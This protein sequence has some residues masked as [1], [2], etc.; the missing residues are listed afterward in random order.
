LKPIIVVGGG[1]CGLLTATQLVRANIP[2]ILIERKKYPFHRVCGEYISNE[3][4]P[5]LKRL[6]LFPEQ[7]DLPEISRFQ[8]SSI[9]GVSKTLPLQLGGFGISRF[10]FDNFLYEQA[11][12]S[13]VD[14]LLEEDVESI[15]FVDNGF[16]I[17]TNKRDLDADFVIGCFGKR[18]KVDV[19]LNR[20]F[21]SKRS[22]YVGIKHHVIV[23]HPRDLIGLHNFPGGY[24]GISR[25][26]NDI[27]NLC[28]L[29]HRD[30]LRQYKNIREMES[31]ILCRNPLLRQIFERAE[32]I[33][34]R[35]ET[36]NEISFETKSPVEQHVLMGGDAAGMI[37]PLCGNG[38]SI[39]MHTSK[40]ISDILRDELQNKQWSRERIEEKY[41]R[42]WN[43]MFARRLWFGRQVQRLFG[44]ETASNLAV[45]FILG[46][47]P[48]ANM[49]IRNTHGE[50]FT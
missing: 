31:V 34:D 47:R 41:T 21:I 36:I 2:C 45:R 10:S 46:F 16:T 26:E 39:A 50:P 25:V 9:T 12:L 40:L 33:F 18:S 14:F 42:E 8:L 24:C 23:D 3:T 30:N 32:F 13:G 37:T 43:N 6:K 44:N 35:P 27:T 19:Q 11:A 22:P 28:Y 29:T 1:I 4:K 15:S 5:F 17:K 38:M 48:L 20:R 49:V 7:F